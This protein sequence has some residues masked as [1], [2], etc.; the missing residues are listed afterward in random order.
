MPVRTD[1]TDF[2]AQEA[3]VILEDIS[4]TM[5]S[6]ITLY[7]TSG[8]EFRSTTPEVFGQGCFSAQG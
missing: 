2:S 3:S 4:N 8:K 6:D 7:T 5:K 1:F